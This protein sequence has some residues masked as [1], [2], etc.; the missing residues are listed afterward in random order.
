MLINRINSIDSDIIE[1]RN[2]TNYKELLDKINIITK[3]G[4]TGK[5]KNLEEIPPNGHRNYVAYSMWKN[6]LNK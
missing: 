2:F 6:W 1:S 4:G 5:P 3:K